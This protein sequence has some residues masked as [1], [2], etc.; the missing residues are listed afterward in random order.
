MTQRK[1]LQR[2]LEDF[3]LHP[4]EVCSRD[5]SRVRSCANLGKITSNDKSSQLCCHPGRH[6]DVVIP[7]LLTLG[8]AKTVLLVNL[9]FVPCQTEGL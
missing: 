8:V 7:C 2:V 6:A 3:S 4:F 1:K 9:A 5:V